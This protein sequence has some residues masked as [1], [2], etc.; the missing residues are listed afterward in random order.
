M[1]VFSGGR[2][3]VPWIVA[4]VM[5]ALGFLAPHLV[6]A[7]APPSTPTPVATPTP[8]ATPAPATPRPEGNPAPD[9]SGG[10]LDFLPDLVP[11]LLPDP[12]E[13]AA[14][15]CMPYDRATGL[16]RMAFPVHPGEADEEV[17]E[18]SAI[19]ARLPAKRTAPA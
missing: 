1:R 15:F 9:R 5:L 10:P 14:V 13:W 18:E 8:P 16:W 4:A 3:P 2:H 17:T 11:D 12:K 19:E 7:Q 6:A